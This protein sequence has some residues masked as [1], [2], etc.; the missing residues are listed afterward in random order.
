MGEH[1]ERI[2]L[3]NLNKEGVRAEAL[4]CVS[5]GDY[6]AVIPRLRWSITRSSDLLSTCCHL[7]RLGPDYD[8]TVL[9][10]VIVIASQSSI[11]L[12][13]SENTKGGYKLSQAIVRLDKQ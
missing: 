11:S 13:P 5:K 2:W 12:P 6:E 3:A 1:R 7:R 8:M 10:L 4:G 9:S